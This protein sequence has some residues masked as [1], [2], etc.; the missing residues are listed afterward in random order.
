MGNMSDCHHAYVHVL[1]YECM[2]TF[3]YLCLQDSFFARLLKIRFHLCG[4]SL[5][6]LSVPKVL[7]GLLLQA[8]PHDQEHFGSLQ[9]HELCLV[10]GCVKLSLLLLGRP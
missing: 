2:R 8:D 5:C 9:Q 4:K 3:V 10:L 1:Q 7:I 6:G